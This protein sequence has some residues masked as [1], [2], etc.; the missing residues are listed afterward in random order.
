ME[1]YDNLVERISKAS[2]IVK[3]DIERKVEAKRAKLSGLVSREGAAQIVAAELGL[4]LEQ[5]RL[6]ISELVHGMKR[7]HVLG[8]IVQMGN[9]RAY[10]K[11]GKEGKVVN[12]LLADESSN[13]KVVLW[14][15]NHI[16]LV[17]N[18]TIKVGDVIEISNANV[19]ND[20]LHLSSFGDIKLS[21]EKFENV[22]AEQ[23]VGNK[24]IKDLKSGARAI[25]RA[26]IVQSFE[27]RYFDAKGRD[28]NSEKVEKRALLNVVL[29]DGS[30]TIRAVMFGDTIKGL[31]LTDEEIFSLELFEKK[32]KE[33][34][35]EEL[36][37]HGNAR[38]NNLY[39]TLEFYIDKILKV[40]ADNLM[41]EFNK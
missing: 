7:S 29:D 12:F 39:G 22:I 24:S 23:V 8:K 21:K 13:V 25:V 11:N 3:E 40:D 37:F 41:T 35:G 14:D 16:S 32:K 9:V 33:I 38:N 15:T 6:K 36:I 26:F 31:G 34:L 10:N 19:R 17:E 4:N 30:E 18:G 20:E 5:E 27:P 2:G 1:N 28:E